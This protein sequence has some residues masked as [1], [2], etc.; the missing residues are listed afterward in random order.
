MKTPLSF[1]LVAVAAGALACSDEGG[2]DRNNTGGSGQVVAQA[3]SSGSGGAAGSGQQSSG[4]ASGAGTGGAA[5]SA[6]PLEITAATP[7][8]NGAT[9]LV[10][11]TANNTGIDGVAQLVKSPQGTVVTN[12]IKDGALCMN[13][14]TAV[15]PGM[16][17]TNYW[18]AELD[19]D[20][21]LVDASGNGSAPPPAADAGADAGSDAGSAPP[22]QRTAV[23]WN[24]SEAKVVGFSFKLDGTQIPTAFRFKGLPYGAD[25][26]ATTYCYP[27]VAAPSGPTVVNVRFDQITKECWNPGGAALLTEPFPDNPDGKLLR[28]IS[29]QIPADVNIPFPFNFC[30]SDIKPILAP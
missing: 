9:A 6:T 8:D 21:K 14:T 18:G 26:S 19:V 20:L 28:T 10:V 12:G 23:G 30:V 2:T 7:N 15:V 27:V 24:A 3:G 22:P 25:S 5:N 16:D 29:W 1:Y 13:G 17:Y 11:D 4:G